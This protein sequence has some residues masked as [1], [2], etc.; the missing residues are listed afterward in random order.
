MAPCEEQINFELAEKGSFEG[1]SE[2]VTS[3]VVVADNGKD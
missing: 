1:H 2:W 3:M